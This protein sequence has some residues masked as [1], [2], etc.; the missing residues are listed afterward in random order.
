MSTAVLRI[1]ILAC[2]FGASLAVVKDGGIKKVLSVLC[3]LILLLEIAS[4]ARQAAWD[5]VGRI[6]AKTREQEAQLLLQGEELRQRLDRTIIEQQLATY[7]SNRAEELDLQILSLR[8]QMRWTMDGI[9]LPEGLV[10]EYRGNTEALSSLQLQIAS[11]LGI[12]LARQNWRQ[13]D[14]SGE[15]KGVAE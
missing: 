3:T 10:C 1:C 11:E 5:L 6:T 4:V 7:I 2:L 8:F 14:E 13:D 9:W 12:P 15:N